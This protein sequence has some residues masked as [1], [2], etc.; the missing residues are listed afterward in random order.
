MSLDLQDAQAAPSP[1]HRAPLEAD[2]LLDLTRACGADDCGLVPIDDPA[3]AIERPHIARAFP[4]TRTL[5]ALVL[6]MNREPV[7]SPARSVAN[8]NSIGSAARS[9]TWR[10]ESCAGSR[11]GAYAPSTQRWPSPWK[12]RPR[13]SAPR[14]SARR[15]RDGTG[16]R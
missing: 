4:Q 15:G 1:A 14:R 7:R 11:T 13:R 9:M 10:G 3:L 8:S 6:R 5:L 12:P 2:E 16:A